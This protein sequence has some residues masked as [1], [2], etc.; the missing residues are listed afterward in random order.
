MLLLSP[1]IILF[2]EE[3]VANFDFFSWNILCCY[4]ACPRSGG[5]QKR[6]IDSRKAFYRVL[7]SSM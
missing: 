4:N 2:L 3:L 1:S 6:Q 5:N 7:K